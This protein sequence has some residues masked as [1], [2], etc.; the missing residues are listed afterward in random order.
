[1]HWQAVICCPYS[2]RQMKLE[3]KSER[4]AWTLLSRSL[5]IFLINTLIS[6]WSYAV[7]GAGAVAFVLYNGGIVV[8]DKS[9]HSA[10]FHPAQLGYFSAFTLALAS[11]HLVSKTKVIEFLNAAWNNKVRTVVS[12]VAFAT[13]VHYYFHEHPYLLADNR[14]YTFYVWSRF[15]KRYNW[16]SYSLVPIYLYALWAIDSGVKHMHWMLRCCL[17]FCIVVAT[18]PQK[19]LEFRY[20]VVPFLLVRLHM[21]GESKLALAAEMLIYVVINAVTFYMFLY[22]PIFWPN[23]LE[24]QRIMW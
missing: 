5:P 19:L 2:F 18:V 14:H 10:C 17:W 4:S 12:G 13:L 22:R 15:F 16:F 11:P 7:V 3:E 24:P 6:C 23:V 8:G 21:K 9:A 1:M 20:F